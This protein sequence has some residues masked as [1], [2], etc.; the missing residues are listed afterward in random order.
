LLQAAKTSLAVMLGWV[1]SQS[2]LH[3]ELPIFAAIAAL[4]VVQPNINQTLGRAIERSLGVVGGVLVA[5]GVGV[6]FG[7]SS[8]IVLLAIVF[9]ILLAWALRLAPSSASQ[10]PISAML[11]L[12]IGATT[13]EYARDRIIE[14]MIGAAAALLVNVLIVPPV[15]LAPAHDTVIRLALE[16]ADTLDRIVDA[17]RFP[18]TPTQ[19]EE[20]MIKA[21]LL[22][23]ML[24][25]AEKALKSAEESLTLNPRHTTNRRLLDVDEEF[26]NRLTSLVTRTIGMTRALRDHY[27]HSL[28]LEPTV[29]AITVELSRSAHDLRL[30][31]AVADYPDRDHLPVAIE[32]PAL[33]EPLLIMRPHPQHWILIGS[34]LEDL[35]RVREEIKGA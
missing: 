4:L 8:W 26:Y 9:C 17:L 18:Q 10:I 11:V 22:R 6:A 29:L 20:M 5:Y 19:I 13:P 30:L 7:K 28:H 15:L 24:N 27:D 33:T 35:R 14:T 2:L 34:L 12:S 23:P 16:V 21:R 3:A 1:L 31:A 25:K 32:P